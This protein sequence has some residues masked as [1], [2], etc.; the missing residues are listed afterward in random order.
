MQIE[1]INNE[2]RVLIGT[3]EMVKVKEFLRKAEIRVTNGGHGSKIK[4]V[5][6]TEYMCTDTGEVKEYAKSSV[7]RSENAKEMKRSFKKLRDLIN[8]NFGGY[9]NE[10]FITLTYKENMTDPKRLYTDFEK[11]R[12]KMTYHFGK[13]EYINVAEP[14]ERGAW[15]CHVL[16]KFKTG[17]K[18]DY[19][20]VNDLWV[21]GSFVNVKQLDNVDNVGAYLSAYLSDI[22]CS[23]V[24]MNDEIELYGTLEGALIVDKLVEVNGQKVSKKF[25]KG[26]RLK[27]YP[28][29]MN[30]YRTSR[31]IKKP[32]EYVMKKS[33]FIANK[34]AISDNV[35]M[36]FNQSI[37]VKDD[38]GNIIN[39]VKYENYKY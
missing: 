22:E 28:K 13:F 11:F 6:A 19:K 15:H 3:N 37:T 20:K 21:H 34:K 38:T 18:L 31:G 7:D 30:L 32:K 29:G 17:T 10:F 1:K 35:E 4:K 9:P 12:K 14:Q 2:P 27:Y 39:S 8:T 25:I 16:C 23:E 24:T 36:T 26:G 5:S 33:E